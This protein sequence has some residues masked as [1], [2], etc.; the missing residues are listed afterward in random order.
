MNKL[1]TFHL[2][3]F[4]FAEEELAKHQ[5]SASQRWGFDFA[6]GVPLSDTKLFLWERVMPDNEIPEMYTLSRAAH[7]RPIDDLLQSPVK[8]NH[9]SSSYIDMLDE[10]AERSNNHAM[11]NN[12]HDLS[13]ED[14]DGGHSSASSCDEESFDE[15]TSSKIFIDDHFRVMPRR[16][17]TNCSRS[18]DSIDISTTSSC[19]MASITCTNAPSSSTRK[20]KTIDRKLDEKLASLRSSPRNREKRQPKITGKRFYP[21]MQFYRFSTV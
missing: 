6:R 8:R 3:I 2:N 7:I 16:E 9:H 18:S 10:L 15:S 5:V 12:V 21:C 13:F 19:T 14:V 20:Q 11:T 4:R 17:P 1:L